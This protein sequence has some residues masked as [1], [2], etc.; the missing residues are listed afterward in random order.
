MRRK[1]KSHFSQSKA[2]L[3]EEGILAWADAFYERSQ[4]WPNQ[5]DGII[6]GTLNEKWRN[7][8]VCLRSGVR[9]LPGGSSLTQ[10]LAQRRGIRNHRGLVHLS[11]RQILAWADAYYQRNGCWPDAYAGPIDEAPG[12]TW[13]AAQAALYVGQRGLPGGSSLSQL[14]AERRGVRNCQRLPKLTVEQIVSWAEAYSRGTG[15]WPSHNSGPIE[16]S[17][18]ETW[19]AVDAALNRGARGLPGGSSLSRLLSKH[20]EARKQP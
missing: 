15:K 11:E 7:V 3:D 1:R 16:G 2:P 19:S 6:I 20:A 12:E 5:K 17:G 4:R 8:D 13:L 10:L 18:G 14:L 9:G